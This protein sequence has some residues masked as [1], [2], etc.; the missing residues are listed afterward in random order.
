MDKDIIW[1]HGVIYLASDSDIAY[2]ISYHINVDVR[3]RWWMV[4][5]MSK[6]GMHDGKTKWTH[7]GRVLQYLTWCTRD[8]S[9]GK[10]IYVRRKEHHAMILVWTEPFH[11]RFNNYGKMWTSGLYK[12][13]RNS[14]LSLSHRFHYF[15]VACFGCVRNFSK[16]V[17]KYLECLFFRS[18]NDLIKWKLIDIYVRE[19]WK[20]WAGRLTK[21]EWIYFDFICVTGTCF[22]LT[23]IIV[24]YITS[25]L[26]LP[27]SVS[28]YLR[29][30]SLATV[31]I[32][33]LSSL[34]MRRFEW[35]T[36][37]MFRLT[38]TTSVTQCN[39]QVI[40]YLDHFFEKNVSQLS[41][42]RVC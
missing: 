16:L 30:S 31:A 42:W 15:F 5:C 1:L 35:V 38:L 10:M 24:I 9:A 28:T 37:A 25:H 4:W 18:F 36:H 20:S 13:N 3:W 11:Y 32:L 2:M 19:A 17:A 34:R 39:Y 21:T 26:F 12:S 7:I 23:Q 33:F 40:S 22:Y 41:W 29:L 27:I 14:S 6:W 8:A